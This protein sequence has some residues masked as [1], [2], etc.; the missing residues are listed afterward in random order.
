MAD[1]RISKIQIRRG[2]IADL[3]I[4]S[5]GE[6]GYATDTQRLFLGNEEYTVGT[7]N[8]AQ[9]VFQ[10]PTGVDYPL[11][12]SNITNAS[13]DRLVRYFKYLASQEGVC[14]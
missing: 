11:T 9:T 1:T 5:P 2:T 12:S 3:P 4:L 13:N 8:A 6:F 7:G 14:I 10:V